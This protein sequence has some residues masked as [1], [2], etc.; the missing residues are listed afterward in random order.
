M[1]VLSFL[2][3]K[4]IPCQKAPS[5]KRRI[6]TGHLPRITQPPRT[7]RK[8]RAPKGALRP[9]RIGHHSTPTGRCQKAPSAKRRIKTHRSSA[10]HGSQEE[11]RKHRA[12]KGALRL[13]I[14]RSTPSAPTFCQKAPSAKRRIKTVLSEALLDFGRG[15]VRKHRA[16]KGALR[17]ARLRDFALRVADCQKAPSA[18]RRIKTAPRRLY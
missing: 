13:V 14:S 4:A 3:L 2:S 10:S 9:R 17:L 6:K 7:V 18:K 8:H 5:A 16:P 15:V 12:P 11:V 1:T